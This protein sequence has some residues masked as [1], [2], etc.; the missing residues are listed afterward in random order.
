MRRNLISYTLFT[1]KK[2]EPSR[3]YDPQEHDGNRYW[4]NIPA[5][6]VANNAF[7]PDHQM[8]LH[9]DP[10][11]HNH[12]LF[13]LLDHMDRNGIIQL[14]TSTRRYTNTEPTFWRLEPLWCEDF[15]IVLCRDIDSIPNSRE[16]QCTL[17]FERSDYLINNIRT[18]P[19][20]NGAL[21]RM[22]AGLCGFRHGIKDHLAGTFDD[23]YKLA[24]GQWGTDQGALM[25]YFID[26]LGPGFTGTHFL[27]AT[28]DALGP[29][30]DIIDGFSA[31][32]FPKEHYATID[33]SY[34]PEEIR[35]TLDS[36]TQWPGQPI[37]ARGEV[38]RKILSLNS[39]V[40][41][42]VKEFTEN[43]PPAKEFYQL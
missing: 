14:C 25:S 24:H 22:L 10:N 36:L 37:D 13:P 41:K 11:T 38:S 43:W 42:K 17:G 21:T 18:H 3:W 34:V 27:D 19:H 12:F 20:H 5:L 33:L 15:N 1:R 28:I 30:C 4:F 6:V 7:Y 16:V 26:R 39:D 2:A 23:Y 31:C 8:K 35:Q 40:A 32:R 29:M 9:V